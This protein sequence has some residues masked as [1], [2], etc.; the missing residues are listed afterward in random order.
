MT[1]QEAQNKVDQWIQTYGVRYFDELTNTV[2]LAE[3]M[4]EFSRLMA[5]TYGEQSFKKETSKEESKAMIKDE[6]AD[7]LFVIIC[8][9]NQMDINLE[10][11]FVK[12]LDKKTNRDHSRHKNNDKL[13][14]D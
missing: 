1:I 3:E 10:E 7:M 12:N 2:V 14:T 4:G 9:A 11:A 5:R 6:M 8:L 13:K